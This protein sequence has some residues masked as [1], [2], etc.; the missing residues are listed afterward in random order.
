MNKHTTYIVT[1]NETDQR[2][3]FDTIEEARQ[4]ADQCRSTYDT[5]GGEVTFTLEKLTKEYVNGWYTESRR[6]AWV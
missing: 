1:V 2:K 5:W 6:P 4:W 3:T